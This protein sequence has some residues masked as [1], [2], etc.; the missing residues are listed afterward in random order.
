MKRPIR[1]NERGMRIG[2]SHP[3]AILTDAEVEQLIA[4]RGPEGQPPRLSL[5]ELALK[6]GLSKSGVKG[7]IDGRRRGQI[8]PTVDKPPTRRTMPKKVRVNLK[9]PLHT[10]AKLHRLGGSAWLTKAVEL[11]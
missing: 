5:R 10:R 4:D 6:W 1:V 7:I 8:G 9:I 3:K 2:E 11:A